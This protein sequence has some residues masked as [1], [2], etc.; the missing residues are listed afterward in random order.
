[1]FEDR[2]DENV[3]KEKHDLNKGNVRGKLIQ[4]AL[5]IVASS[6]L[7]GVY[8]IVDMLIAGR[9]LGSRGVSAI[10]NSSQVMNMATQIAIGLTLGGNIL[11]GQY[12]GAKKE[13]ER[14]EATGNLLILCLILGVIASIALFVMA[15]TLMTLLNAPSR[16]EAVIYLKICAI[17]Y[18]TIL[19]YNGCS[20]IMRAVGNS[21][22]PFICIGISTVI[23]IVLDVVFVIFL[24]MGVAGTA[25]AT[26]IAQA[27]SF[28]V[29]IMYILK[30]KEYFGVQLEFMKVK[31]EKIQKI[32]KLGIPCALQWTI[33]SIS[34]L[35]V[36]YFINAY[37]L[38]VSAGNGISIKIKDFCQLF[39]SA[40]SGAASTMIAQALGAK[41]FDRGKEIMYE[42]MKIT[43]GMAVLIIVIVELAAPILAGCFTTNPAVIENAV[44]NL[45]IEIIGQL[46]YASFLIYHSLMTG[47]GHTWMVMGSSFVNCILVRV[48]L[49]IIFNQYWGLQ[50]VYLGCMIAPASSIPIG[51]IYTKTNVWRKSLVS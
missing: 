49:V 6:L 4:Y 11:I 34:W 3:T 7:Q 19:L 27:I 33:A 29:A 42:A 20:A 32:F 47:A 10:N 17:G 28:I 5:P 13:R 38:D 44:L 30:N 51:W 35:V 2:G 8:S 18:V 46:F 1:L 36:T 12:F 24:K 45:R 15:P 40:M 48:I 21:R 9:F 43:I 14:K 23:N 16:Q 39:I 37:G 26:I 31:L 22:R 50:G 25:L 41:M